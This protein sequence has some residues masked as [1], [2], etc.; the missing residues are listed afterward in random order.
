MSGLISVFDLRKRQLVRKFMFG[1]IISSKTVTRLFRQRVF[2]P[3][4]FKTIHKTIFS[5]QIISFLGIMMMM[6]IL[7]N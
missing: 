6:M 7:F 4:V 3:R 1:P 2:E 5:Q